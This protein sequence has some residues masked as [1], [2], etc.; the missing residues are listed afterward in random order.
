MAMP[1]RRFVPVFAALAIAVAVTIVTYATV[2]FGSFNVARAYIRGDAVA[3]DRTTFDLGQIKSS[4]PLDVVVPVRNLG[5]DGLRI[6]GSRATCGCVHVASKL[7]LLIEPGA[8]GV[9][10]LS[11]EADE[12]EREFEERIKL[13]VDVADPIVV[14]VKAVVK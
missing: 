13:F 14:T 2:R 3:V 7:P 6:T 10:R 1:S 12:E 5:A 4:V 11:V 9:V 8:I